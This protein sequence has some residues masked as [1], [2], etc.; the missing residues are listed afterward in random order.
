MKCII[1]PKCKQVIVISSLLALVHNVQIHTEDRAL[2]SGKS[3]KQ[4]AHK[5][6]L[7]LALDKQSLINT[8]LVSMRKK[9]TLYEG[10]L[11]PGT[12]E[13]KKCLTKF[14]LLVYE[15]TRMADSNLYI[16]LLLLRHV[17]KT[18]GIIYILLLI[19]ICI[20]IYINNV[21]I[22]RGLFAMW[23]SRR[24][25]DPHRR[26]GPR[27]A[28]LSVVTPLRGSMV[29]GPLQPPKYSNQNYALA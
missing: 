3:T 23:A 7:V 19:F 27:A 13:P 6:V 1:Y 17:V 26:M 14:L 2:R 25:P 24:A 29:R 10:R 8:T 22:T 5:L 15:K 4:N 20:Y 9:H 12:L 16:Y 11:E 18:V 28:A 21:F